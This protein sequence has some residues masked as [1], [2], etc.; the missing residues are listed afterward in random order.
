MEGFFQEVWERQWFSALPGQLLQL[1]NLW[2]TLILTYHTFKI[3]PR[4]HLSFLGNNLVR[5]FSPTLNILETVLHKLKPFIM[6]SRV[7]TCSSFHK[8]ARD[9]VVT[10]I[11]PL[12]HVN[13]L[14]IK[15]PTFDWPLWHPLLT[16]MCQ[17]VPVN[18]VSQH[19]FVLWHLFHCA[20]HPLAS[21]SD[22]VF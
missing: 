2:H 15:Y 13:N 14:S 11:F 4:Y 19:D 1:F 12:I 5:D 6:Y 8:L 21:N 22:F 7:V 10:L 3:W 20:M 16:A 17:R 9:L 18:G